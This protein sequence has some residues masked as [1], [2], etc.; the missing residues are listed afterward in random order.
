MPS[1]PMSLSYPS[2]HEFLLRSREGW[3]TVPDRDG[4]PRCV[5]LLLVPNTEDVVRA[6][7]LGGRLLMSRTSAEDGVTS[8]VEVAIPDRCLGSQR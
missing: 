1:K 7:F 6:H 8:V 2:A 5:D 3:L 4:T